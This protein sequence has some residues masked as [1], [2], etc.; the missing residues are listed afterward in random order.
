[1]AGSGRHMM[2]R[3]VLAERAPLYGMAQR[4]GLGPLPRAAMSDFLR[5]RAEAG[6]KAMTPDAAE[7]VVEREGTWVVSDPF[8]AGWLRGFS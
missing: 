1:M 7:L 6:R 4:I 5:A 3:L 8:F 2:E